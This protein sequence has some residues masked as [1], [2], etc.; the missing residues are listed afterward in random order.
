MGERRSAALNLPGLSFRDCEKQANELTASEAYI[1][2]GLRPMDRVADLHPEPWITK[3]N[4]I[5]MAYYNKHKVVPRRITPEVLDSITVEG[6]MPQN[7]LAWYRSPLTGE[8]PALDAAEFTPGGVYLRVLTQEETYFLA[9]ADTTL[10][11]L[12]TAGKIHDPASGEVRDGARLSPVLYY[13][14]YGETGLLKEGFSYLFAP[15]G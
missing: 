5:A 11:G 13:R 1:L 15:R 14:Y 6:S 7:C 4:M 10:T 3:I 12:E 2:A 8:Y 9:Q